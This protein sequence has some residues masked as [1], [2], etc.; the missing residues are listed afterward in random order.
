MKEVEMTA[1]LFFLLLIMAIL[2]ARVKID[3]DRR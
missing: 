2:G 3:I 1:S